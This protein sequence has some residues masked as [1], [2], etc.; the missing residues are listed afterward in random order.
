MKN[1]NESNEWLTVK[2]AKEYLRMRSRTTLY[3]TLYKHNILVNKLSG[4]VLINRA[5][6]LIKMSSHSYR[7]GI[8]S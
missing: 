3:Q 5:D 6:L 7:L 4:R 8:V 2:E 1:Q